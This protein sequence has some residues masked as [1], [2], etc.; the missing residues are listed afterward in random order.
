MAKEAWHHVV[1]LYKGGASIQRS[2]YEVVQDEADAFAMN[3]DEE[4]RELY[5]RLT[6]LAVSLRDHG[7]KNT[8][9]NWIKCKFLKA[10]MHYHKAMSSVIRER[11]DFHTLSSSEV[12]DE[13]VAMRILDK[14]TDN[15][16]L[17]SQRVKKPNLALKAKIIVEERKKRKMR[18]AT[19]KIQNMIIMN[20]WLLLQGNF[21]ARRTQGP[22][23][24]RTTQVGSRASN[25]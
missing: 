6:T 15:A 20:T 25:M 1:S 8:D 12:L 22:T 16:V 13:F 19:P 23:S 24:T 7:S 2:N 10:M 17:R 3:E 9:G 4:P 5:R 18:R 14:T 11:P 21:G